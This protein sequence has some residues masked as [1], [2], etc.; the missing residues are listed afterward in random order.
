MR[1]LAVSN[2]PRRSVTYW[3]GLG[4]SQMLIRPHEGDAMN[5]PLQYLIVRAIRSQ[6]KGWHGELTSGTLWVGRR[7][8]GLTTE[9]TDRRKSGGSA[10]VIHLS[11]LAF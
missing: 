11:S 3:S 7:R 1:D 6:R 8:P 2:R 9:T 5:W 4:S 10:G